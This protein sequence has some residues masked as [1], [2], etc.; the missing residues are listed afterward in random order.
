VY[1]LAERW[2]A[3]C[4]SLRPNVLS[5]LVGVNDFWHKHKHGYDGTLEKYET[6]YH[7]LIKRTKEFLPDLRL[8]IGEPFV[9]RVGAVDDSWFPE[10]DSYRLAAKRVAESAGARFVPFQ[11][12]FDAAVKIA[13]PERWAADGVHPTADGAALMAHTW[14]KIVGA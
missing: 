7:A 13:P 11:A 2:D 5:I 8:V 12:M 4:L 10:F 6:D 9:L 14:L 1:Q 3:D